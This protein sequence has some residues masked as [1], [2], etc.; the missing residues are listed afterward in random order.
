MQ[1]ESLVSMSQH[2]WRCI[3]LYY[4]LISMY[5]QK[6]KRPFRTIEDGPVTG[7]TGF[8]RVKSLSLFPSPSL[9]FSGWVPIWKAEAHQVYLLALASKA[10]TRES[11]RRGTL[12]YSRGRQW[13][14][15]DGAN[16]LSWGFISSLHK[17]SYLTSF[18]HWIFL[19]YCSFLISLYISN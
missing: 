15:V 8:P 9:S 5:N 11:L 6:Y 14:N 7:K 1:R 12:H 18:L 19:L 10:H 16:L 2:C 3:I 13:P 4:P 17:L